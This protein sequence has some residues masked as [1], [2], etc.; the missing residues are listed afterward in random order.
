[1]SVTA[2]VESDGTHRPRSDSAPVGWL[3]LVAGLTALVLVLSAGNQIYDTNYDALW[4]A[5]ALLAGDLPY[6]D[7][8]DWGV[9]LTGVLSALAQ[10]VVGYRLIG[11]FGMQWLLIIAGQ[12]LAFDLGFR[13]SRSIAA[14]LVTFCLSLIILIATPT[15]SYPKMLI[16]PLAL[17][18]A[19]RYLDRPNPGRSA[20]LGLV[21]TIGFLFRHDHGAHVA[22]AAA[23]SFA[24][25]RLVRPSSRSLRSLLV[26]GASYSAVALATITPW[27]VLVQVNEGLPEYM[28]QRVALYKSWSANDSPFVALRTL[29]PVQAVAPE[30]PPPAA[31][32][33]ISVVWSEGTGDGQRGQ[34]ERQYNLRMLGGPDASRRW[35]YEV[36][37]V[38]DTRLLTLRENMAD[39][40]GI[41]WERLQR[42][43][44]PLPT[45]ANALMWLFQVTLLVPI[46]LIG[47]VVID[48]VRSRGR[49]ESLDANTWPTFLAAATLALIDDQIFRQSSYF[50]ATAP[51]TAALGARLL[52]WGDNR[53]MTGT[54]VP[55]RFAHYSA[56]WMRLRAALGVATVLI[57]VVTSVAYT[58][59]A[60]EG[61][62]IFE[63]V[64]P[65][66]AQ[67]LASPPIEGALPAAEMPR[68]TREVWRMWGKGSND[69]QAVM[70]RY[71]HDCTAAGDRVLVTGSTPSQV[72]Y[73][74]ER[75][76][77]GGHI[78]WHHRWL[79]DPV[80][81]GHS[82]TRLQ[83]QSVPFAFS[84]TDPVLD[85][86][87]SY[88]RIRAYLLQHYVELEGSYGLL[89]IDTR[90]TPTGTFATLGFPCFR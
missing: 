66:F 85:D 90:R 48:V 46:L 61:L 33:T 40:D 52:V 31:A 1:M 32:G 53:T 86:F 39:A 14:S 22:F 63:G 30:K 58:G 26:E 47:S 71:L 72:N 15:Y 2:R 87:K 37:N 49:L 12:V 59:I 76:F 62:N 4:E 11:E 16:Y 27:L 18:L 64:R 19:C 5:T 50:V 8:Y 20:I 51:L 7:F 60:S 81:E 42:L 13:L 82:L 57:T 29:N 43:N 89:L 41:N 25:A 69:K 44:S 6:R 9:P 35:R 73:L 78:L 65:S 10:I 70:F 17:W 68:V 24:L 56:V 36:A 77:A 55:N 83:Q 38:Y 75:P 21:T 23:L 28:R 34:L 84:T 74:A 80:H 45:Q 79:S 3:L 54:P 88:P 67:L